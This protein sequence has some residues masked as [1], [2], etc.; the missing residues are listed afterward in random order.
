MYRLISE[1]NSNKIE[2][3]PGTFDDWRLYLTRPNETSYSPKTKDYFVIIQDLGEIY[4][5]S[6]IHDDFV[7]FY[8]LTSREMDS[9]VLALIKT[10][11]ATYGAHAEELEVWF[12]VIYASMLAEE[13]NKNTQFG[14]RIKRLGMYQILIEKKSP[15]FAANFLSG[16][17]FA[18]I[19]REMQKHGF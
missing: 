4:G 1:I 6:K 14:K 18:E 5:Y 15:N 7:K 19:D 9:E 13:N 16:R 12:T 10:L 2:F 17:S 8:D 3:G 11:A